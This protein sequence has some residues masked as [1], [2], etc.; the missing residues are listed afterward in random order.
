MYHSPTKCLTYEHVFNSPKSR[1]AGLSGNACIYILKETVTSA[2]VAAHSAIPLAMCD[3]AFPVP[4]NT[5][6]LPFHFSHP[7][8][9]GVYLISGL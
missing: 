7:N 9:Y 8:V 2:T 3:P 6:Y 1:T 4:S 5:H